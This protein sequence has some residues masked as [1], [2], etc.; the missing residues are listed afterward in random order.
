MHDVPSAA[1]TRPLRELGAH[2]ACHGGER[3]AVVVAGTDAYGVSWER[4][5]AAFTPAC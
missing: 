3:L 1:L 2:A 5:V 4:R